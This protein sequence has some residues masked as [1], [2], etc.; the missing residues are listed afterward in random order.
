LQDNSV[1]HLTHFTGFMLEE[2]IAAS[3]WW[4]L[5][6][7]EMRKMR[8]NDNRLTND[9]CKLIFHWVI[10]EGM[11]ENEKKNILDSIRF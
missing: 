7:S 9:N 4:D 2:E 10:G 8:K 11:E 5:C 1:E 3:L 6:S